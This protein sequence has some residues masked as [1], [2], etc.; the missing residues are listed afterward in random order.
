MG[1]RSRA[2]LM[3]EVAKATCLWGPRRYNQDAR[4]TESLLFLK[5]AAW[6]REGGEH[7]SRHV[8]VLQR[9]SFRG[10]LRGRLESRVRLKRTCL[11]VFLS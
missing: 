6:A 8:S 3:S 1:I 4:T 2:P 10:V 7:Q 11:C 5:E 9:Q